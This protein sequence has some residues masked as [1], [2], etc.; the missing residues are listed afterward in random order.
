ML[1]PE[2]TDILTFITKYFIRDVSTDELLTT[3]K[4]RVVHSDSEGVRT[5]NP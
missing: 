2:G 5:M 1:V 4:V 3:E